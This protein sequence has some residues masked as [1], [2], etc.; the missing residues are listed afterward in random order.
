MSS[1]IS[2]CYIC[3]EK[4]NWNKRTPKITQ[5]CEKIICLECMTKIFKSNKNEIIC[6][7]CRALTSFP[8]KLLKSYIHFNCFNCGSKL[9]QEEEVLIQIDANDKEKLGCSNCIQGKGKSF[10]IIYKTIIQEIKDSEESFRI[11]Y[12]YLKSEIHD[13]IRPHVKNLKNELSAMIKKFIYKG[14]INKFLDT[15]TLKKENFK[16][17]EGYNDSLKYFEKFKKEELNEKTISYFI[18]S[19]RKYNKEKVCIEEISQKGLHFLSNSQYF[20]NSNEFKFENILNKISKKYSIPYC[21]SSDA[22]FSFLINNHKHIDRKFSSSDDIMSLRKKIEDIETE[23]NMLKEKLSENKLTLEEYKSQHSILLE[24]FLDVSLRDKNQYN[25]K[26]T[27]QR[28]DNF[29]IINIRGIENRHT[30]NKINQ[31]VNS[32]LRIKTVKK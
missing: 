14:I 27:E 8:P 28:A 15:Y 10:I 3:I 22:S 29:I 12:N 25:D 23:N 20:L 26:L 19:I 17:F 7:L 30:A 31:S 1:E 5:C 9:N 2:S 32:Q 16:V 4:F 24:K 21:I 18:K 11:D 6:P 13:I